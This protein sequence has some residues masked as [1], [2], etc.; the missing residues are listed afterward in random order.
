MLTVG[1]VGVVCVVQTFQDDKYVPISKATASERN[2]SSNN[3]NAST[4][5]LLP[6][7]RRRIKLQAIAVT[8]FRI[9]RILHAGVG[10]VS[11]ELVV[12]S[13]VS[14]SSSPPLP[15]IVVEASWLHDTNGNSNEDQETIRRLVDAL[16]Q[17]MIQT[18]I[19]TNLPSP[20]LKDGE[21]EETR[22]PTTSTSTS[23]EDVAAIVEQIMVMD[24]SRGDTGNRN[25][26]IGASIRD[27][28][29][30]FAAA[31]SLLS[32]TDRSSASDMKYLLELQSTRDRLEYIK[33]KCN[34]SKK[35]F[36]FF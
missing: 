29:F 5:G 11:G 16:Q 27:E 7:T 14:L 34:K 18:T 15:F 9:E 4:G 6:F 12:A 33:E 21:D 8:R 26:N 3:P 17:Q 28:I 2:N 20:P 35:R 31:T 24:D 23:W 1:D 36:L 13:P 32:A 30:S 10:D 19:G 22:T 25:H